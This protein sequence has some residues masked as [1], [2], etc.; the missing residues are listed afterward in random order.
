MDQ[1]GR[2]NTERI[3][4]GDRR[5]IIHFCPWMAKKSQQVFKKWDLRQSQPHIKH[6]ASL[7]AKE[8]F[9][10]EYYNE[11]QLETRS[12]R[13]CPVL[14]PDDPAPPSPT[15]DEKTAAAE[16]EE[17][18]T[19]F[20]EKGI[21]ES[22]FHDLMKAAGDSGI[23]IPQVYNSANPDLDSSVKRNCVCLANQQRTKGRP[24][25]ES[26]YSSCQLRAAREIKKIAERVRHS[27]VSAVVGMHG[28]YDGMRPRAQA[29]PRSI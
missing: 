6:P 26:H 7:D 15:E 1:A 11:M 5:V 4:E 25:R 8:V 20:S 27:R 12:A 2:W 14:G 17:M 3:A 22:C 18:R 9:G 24:K 13:E 19:N 21:P 16:E 28:Y 10:F 23:N 29:P